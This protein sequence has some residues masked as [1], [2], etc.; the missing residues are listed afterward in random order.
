M[1]ATIISLVFLVLSIGALFIQAKYFGKC[2]LYP[3]T[4]VKE[5]KRYNVVRGI[6][7]TCFWLSA[8]ALVISLIVWYYQWGLERADKVVFVL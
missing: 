8:I 1:Y 3:R 5:Q 6:I 2:W 7:N 4:M